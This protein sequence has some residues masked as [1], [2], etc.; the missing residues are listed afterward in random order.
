M[1]S[2]SNLDTATPMTLPRSSMIGPP[3]LPCC[4]AALVI[5]NA[6]RRFFKS[7]SDERS[8]YPTPKLYKAYRH[9]CQAVGREPQSHSPRMPSR[10][11]YEYY[12][13]YPTLFYELVWLVDF[14]QKTFKHEV[15]EKRK[16]K[17]DFKYKEDS[18]S[19][20]AIAY[21]LAEPF[22]AIL[23]NFHLFQ[24]SLWVVLWV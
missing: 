14:E 16:G 13:S 7:V 19:L 4:K 10:K 23:G 24:S 21:T 1:V 2:K 5:P 18:T 6:V 8:R 12:N 11:S 9:Y 20:S 3:L 17:E 22:K 15:T